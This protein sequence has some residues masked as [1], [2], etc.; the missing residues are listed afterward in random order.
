MTQ[1]I[2]IIIESLNDAG[3]VI[4]K[5]IVATKSVVKPN[6]IMDL[7]FRH[8]EQIDL[9]RHIQQNLLDKQSSYFKEELT[10]CPK[11][12]G[13]LYKSGYVKSDFHSVF[14]D[15]KGKCILIV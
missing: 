8:S 9:L 1:Q 7:G 6:T 15:H 2:R 3:D 14:T 11:C 13:K 12:D 4:G 5:E 10:S